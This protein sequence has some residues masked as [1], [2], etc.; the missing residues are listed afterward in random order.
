[1]KTEDIKAFYAPTELKITPLIDGNIQVNSQIY[2]KNGIVSI[3]PV[4]NSMGAA[5]ND[6]IDKFKNK[7][8]KQAIENGEYYLNQYIN[9]K[10]SRTDRI[11]TIINDS[12]RLET[13][14]MLQ[15]YNNLLVLNEESD[16]DELISLGKKYIDK[17]K[18][19]QNSKWDVVV[20]LIT[21]APLLKAEKESMATSF[22]NIKKQNPDERP[23]YVLS[24][25]N[26]Y[27]SKY[28]DFKGNRFAEIYEI[29]KKAQSASDKNALAEQKAMYEWL[30]NRD[31]ESEYLKLIEYGNEYLSKY[32]AAKDSLWN[33][34]SKMVANA[35][36]VKARVKKEEK[37]LLA[38][39]NGEII[40]GIINP[41]ADKGKCMNVIA[42]LFQ[43][44]SANTGLFRVS[45]DLPP[46]LVFLE[47]D[48]PFRGNFVKGI[49]KITGVLQYE[50]NLRGQNT[51]PKLKMLKIEKL[52]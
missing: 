24:L 35:E 40:D 28:K 5:F 34:V 11:V 39:C 26:D 23:E 50:T 37:E 14:R 17:Y 41:F 19:V 46:E 42:A 4:F 51:V 52:Q 13:A 6:V 33:D 47:F 2:N 8:Y 25:I 30:K 49:A 32:S 38:K 18:N 10:D 9:Q 16:F 29:Q 7:K 22:E 1:M 45:D 3:V 12:K 27:I 31:K 44:T 21:K 15:E 36:R 20:R 43:I 48:K